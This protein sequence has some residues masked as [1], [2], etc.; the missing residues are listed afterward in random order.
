MTSKHLAAGPAAAADDDDDDDLDINLEGVDVSQLNLDDDDDDDDDAADAAKAIAAAKASKA[1]KAA[2][3]AAGSAGGSG[4][5]HHHH[6]SNEHGD[7]DEDGEEDGEGD[8]DEDDEEDDDEEDEEPK[9]KYQ[10]VSPGMTEM[11]KQDAASCLA[12]HDKFLALGTH[13][14]MIYILDFSGN[15]IKRFPAHTGTITDLSIDGN[16]DYIASSSDD[17]NT[18]ETVYF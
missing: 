17:G 1:A 12:V 4:S 18:N 8:D 3:A 6:H 10:R 2:A 13:F 14:G 5:K 11:L 9:L 16:G 15:E 7:G